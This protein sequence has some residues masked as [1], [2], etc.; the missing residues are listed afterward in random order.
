MKLHH[1]TRPVIAA[2]GLDFEARAVRGPGVAVIYGQSRSKYL[3]ELHS[4]ARLGARG[5]ISFGIAGGISPRL[6]PGDIVVAEA[7]VTASG[8]FHTSREWSRAL[9]QALPK[10]HYMPIFGAEAPVL[11]VLEKEALW[12]ATGAGT[13]DMESSAAAEVAA[14]HKL[15][16]AALRV[17]LDPAHRPIPLSAIAG[18]RADG[19]TDGTAVLRS[20]MRRP[21]D[22][23]GVLRLANDTR[24]AT[25]A[26]FRC[27]QSLGPFLG[28][29]DAMKLPLNVE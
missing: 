14:H 26:L 10:A 29:L 20:L 25:Q 8:I 9:R 18:A 28:L 5:V 12:S 22:F 3:Q 13:V 15:P 17:V 4:K 19:K 24:I 11:T 7:V 21:Q 2:V 1:E 23:R 27:R 16:F 6:R